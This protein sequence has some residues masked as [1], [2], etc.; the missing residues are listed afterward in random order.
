MPRAEINKMMDPK[1]MT[2][3]SGSVRTEEDPP[4]HKKVEVGDEILFEA[5]KYTM[6]IPPTRTIPFIA[7]NNIWLKSFDPNKDLQQPQA[8]AISMLG[9][10]NRCYQ[11][12]SNA[13]VSF[14]N[15]NFLHGC[16]SPPIAI[17]CHQL[18]RLVAAAAISASATGGGYVERWGAG[19]SRVVMI[20]LRTIP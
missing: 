10:K 14:G 18:H 6:T 9:A 4:V 19:S 8:R 11:F 2:N 15:C 13:L 7:S 17:A 5:A 12:N 16:M 1:D 3:T 20:L